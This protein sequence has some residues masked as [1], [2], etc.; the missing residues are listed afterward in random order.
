MAAAA[1]VVA[2][3]AAGRAVADGAAWPGF[4]GQPLD[5][6]VGGVIAV[7][8]RF[9]GSKSYVVR[10]VPFAYPTFIGGKGDS[11]FQVKGV[12]D[13]RYRLI[14]VSGFEV[15]PLAGWRFG[16]QEDDASRLNGLGDVDGGLIVGGYA[17]YHIGA[18]M[19][20]V[21][22]HHQV[23]GDDTG[24][25][26]R[27]GVEAKHRLTPRLELTAKGGATW[28]SQDYMTSFFGVTAT[29]AVNSGLAQFSASSGIKDSF[30]SLTADMKLDECWDLKVFGQYSRLL[31][32]AADSPITETPNQ[33]VGGAALTYRFTIGR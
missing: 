7:V 28:A 29:Q 24:G 13:L 1:A 12:D 17:G 6:K 10:G 15:G 20:Y 5:V 2:L 11:K 14:S 21:S 19:P 27:F 22:Y 26:L 25:Q 9:E 3:F 32:D 18:L 8:P 31:D 33:F 4:D 16:R 30:V 23:T